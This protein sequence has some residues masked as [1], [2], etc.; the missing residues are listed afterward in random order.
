M[1]VQVSQEVETKINANAWLVGYT[2]CWLVGY[3]WLHSLLVGTNQL[4]RLCWALCV[5]VVLVV[6]GLELY[7]D[8][9]NFAAM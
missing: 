4:F 1:K 7:Q 6:V 8:H 3:K 5:G 2:P 9:G